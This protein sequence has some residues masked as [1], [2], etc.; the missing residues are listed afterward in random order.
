MVFVL[1]GTAKFHPRFNIGP[2]LGTAGLVG[3]ADWGERWPGWVDRSIEAKGIRSATWAPAN[4]QECSTRDGCAI[5]G[6]NRLD[7]IET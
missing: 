4:D 2:T 7:N 1:C 3:V 5:E 6:R